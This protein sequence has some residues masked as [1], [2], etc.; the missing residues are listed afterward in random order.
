MK[1]LRTLAVVISFS[2]VLIACSKELQKGEYR[3]TFSGNH[4]EGPYTTTYDFTI[5]Q[6]KKTEL[7]LMEK[8]SGTTS[9]LT[10]HPNDSISGM[11]G[12]AGQIYNPDKNE[13]SSFNAIKVE[14]TYNSNTITG[15]FFTTFLYDSTEY[16][17]TGEFVIRPL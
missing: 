2:F 12:F 13:N 7:K 8:K 3:G 15:R 11:I 1:T 16:E 6:S 4:P 10:K 17:S 14:G 9:T 5:T